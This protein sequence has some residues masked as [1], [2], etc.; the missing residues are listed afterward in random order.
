MKRNAKIFFLLAVLAMLPQLASA[1]FRLGVKGGLVVNKLSFDKSTFSAD[2]RTGFA[3][4]LQLDLG[5]PLGFGIDASVM[6]S[7]RNDT[8]SSMAGTFRRDYIEIPVHVRY[9]LNLVGLNRV[10]V[11][12]VFTGPNFALLCHE[13]SNIEW[14]NRSTVT[15][16]DVGFGVELL[17]HVQVQACYGIGMT[18]AFKYVGIDKES[19]IIHGKDRCWTITAAYLF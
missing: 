16:W 1:Q 3:V 8:F 2:N 5:L 7:H 19:E 15:S 4:G 13:S 11:P 10:L 17:R 18:D 14:N 6:Y 9:G 12:Y